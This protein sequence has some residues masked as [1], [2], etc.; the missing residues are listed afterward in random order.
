[1]L[2]RTRLGLQ[3]SLLV[4]YDALCL[5]SA[6]FDAGH[7]SEAV[8]IANAIFVLLGPDMRNHK[9]VLSQLGVLDGQL[10]V[11]STAD[12]R[13]P[14]GTAL[15]AVE[16]TP[17]ST[18]D[19][20]GGYFIESVPFG[21]EPLSAGRRLPVPD[22]WNEGV[23]SGIGA[24]T[25]LTRLQVVRIMR[26]QD[27]G[28]HL[29]DHIK[30]ETYLAVYVKGTGFLY[31]PSADSEVSLPV[32]GALEATVRQ[33]AHEVLNPMR[34]LAHSARHALREAAKTGPLYPQYFELDPATPPAQS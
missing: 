4:Q 33:M 2:R 30:D 8:R 24:T 3:Y 12:S 34:G 7:R 10:T 32:E 26:D 18:D 11:P 31:K 19:G 20:Q 1:M 16:A 14:H 23:L 6:M 13:G 21:H 29:D 27:G 22:W 25:T 28:A 17:Y 15:I 5:S 9:S